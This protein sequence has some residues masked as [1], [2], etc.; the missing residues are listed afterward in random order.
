MEA[1]GKTIGKHSS[2]DDILSMEKQN[3]ASPETPSPSSA[4]VVISLLNKVIWKC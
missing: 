2:S 1:P 3:D 4:Q